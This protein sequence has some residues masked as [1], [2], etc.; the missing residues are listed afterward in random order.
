MATTRGAGASGSSD[1]NAGAGAN[2]SVTGTS[3]TSAGAAA[4]GTNADSAATV[5][6]RA[7]DDPDFAIPHA[8]TEPEAPKKVSAKKAG[9]E[10]VK[11]VSVEKVYN[12]GGTSEPTVTVSEDAKG[13][14]SF[15][16]GTVK[17]TTEDEDKAAEVAAYEEYLRGQ[18][19]DGVV[20]RD[21][22]EV[23]GI[24]GTSFDYGGAPKDKK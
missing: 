5:A 1:G 6:E 13:G 11:G 23:D 4:T 10:E 24:G 12:L 18:N 21:A 22:G 20:I 9:V 17:A 3:G 19:P 2:E 14:F 15:D 8:P 7:T 16:Y